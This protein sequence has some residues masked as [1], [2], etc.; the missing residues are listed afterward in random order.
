MAN[1][2]DNPINSY[3]HHWVTSS[4]RSLSLTQPP[5][6]RT[7][8]FVADIFTAS[9]INANI[10]ASFLVRQEAT[11][12]RSSPFIPLCPERGLMLPAKRAVSCALK[13]RYRLFRFLT[14][15]LYLWYSRI[16]SV[17]FRSFISCSPLQFTVSIICKGR[18]GKPQQLAVESVEQVLFTPFC[19]K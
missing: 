16:A 14:S 5:A 2:K 12:R 15:L 9:S 3:V 18:D 19:F 8:V 7:T 10:S 6:T 17:C 13:D 11:S 4:P 1:E